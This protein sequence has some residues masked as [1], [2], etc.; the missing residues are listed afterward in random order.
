MKCERCVFWRKNPD[1]TE[2]GKCLLLSNE[3]PLEIDSGVIGW[4]LCEH[5]GPAVTFET[6]NWFHCCH[7]LLKKIYR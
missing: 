3:K 4:P 7:F 2:L 5:D 6:K 1:N